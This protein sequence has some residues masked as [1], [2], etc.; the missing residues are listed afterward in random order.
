[1]DNDKKSNFSQQTTIWWHESHSL[2]MQLKG[3]PKLLLKTNDKKKIYFIKHGLRELT[4]WDMDI[5]ESKQK[6][7]N[8]CLVETKDDF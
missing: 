2:R 6:L 4:D 5:S 3:P 1:M 7:Y 8:Q